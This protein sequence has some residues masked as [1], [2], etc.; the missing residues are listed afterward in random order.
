MRRG[1]KRR[2]ITT[3]KGKSMHFIKGEEPPFSKDF[4]PLEPICTLQWFPIPAVHQKGLVSFWEIE[5]SNPVR[6][7][8]AAGQGLHRRTSTWGW[9]SLL[10][11]QG[12]WNILIFKWRKG[13][14]NRNKQKE[15]EK[16]HWRKT[17][18]GKEKA[19]V[20]FRL[21]ETQAH[22]GPQHAWCLV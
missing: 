20:S 3:E 21:V 7:W 2:E 11:C 18:N 19:Q 15:R 17:G 14:P 5:M 4:L 6:L 9:E 8:R 13:W 10:V 1:E 12:S 22:K 16:W